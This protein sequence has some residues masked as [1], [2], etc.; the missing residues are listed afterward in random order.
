LFV[1]V[2]EPELFPCDS[3]LVIVSKEGVK[4]RLGKLIEAEPGCLLRAGRYGGGSVL[5]GTSI[6]K[7]TGDV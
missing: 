2:G 7:V 4:V 3:W 5:F 6:S 1:V